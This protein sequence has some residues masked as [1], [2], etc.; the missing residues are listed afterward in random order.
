MER[1]GRSGNDG[2]SIR[3]PESCRDAASLCPVHLGWCLPRSPPFSSEDGGLPPPG[4]HLNGGQNTTFPSGPNVGGRISF[5]ENVSKDPDKYG[6]TINTSNASRYA[7]PQCVCRQLDFNL[8]FPHSVHV[9]ASHN[10]FVEPVQVKGSATAMQLELPIRNAAPYGPPKSKNNRRGAVSCSCDSHHEENR[11]GFSSVNSDDNFLSISKIS[12]KPNPNCATD[13]DSKPF[14]QKLR[15]GTSRKENVS[16]DTTKPIPVFEAKGTAGYNFGLPLSSPLVPKNKYVGGQRIRVCV[17]KRPLTRAECRRGQADV[18]TTTP[19]ED[20]VIVRESKEAV[21]LSEYI[22]QHKFYFDQVF[23]EGSS[24]EEVYQT[25]AFPLVQH[26]LNGGKATCFAYGQTGAGK[27]HTMLGSS[28]GEPGLYV[29]AVRDIFAH[30][31]TTHTHSSLLVYASFF[32]IYCGQLYD[33]LDSRKR[34][35]AREDGQKVVHISGLRNVRVDSVSSVLKVISQGTAERTQGVS[36]VNPLSS[37]SHAVLQIQLRGPNQQT[38][39]RMWFVDLAG[40]ERASDA[41][42][43]DRQTRMEGAEIN[44]SLLALKECIRS[45]DKDESHTPFRQSKLTQVLKDS[46]IGNS[47]T[48]MIASISPGHQA[49]EHTLNTLRY[50]DRVKELKGQAEVRGRRRCKTGPFSK[51][52][53]S[54]SNVGTP[55]KATK[56]SE[57]IEPNTPARFHTAG[58]FLRLTP[59]YS[60]CEEETQSKGRRQKILESEKPVRGWLA[61]GERESWTKE[62]DEEEGRRMTRGNSDSHHYVR[63]KSTRAAPALKPQTGQRKHKE[64]TCEDNLTFMVKECGFHRRKKDNSPPEWIEEERICEV[65]R[66]RERDLKKADTEKMRHL[67]QYHQHLQ[68]SVPSLSSSVHFVPSFRCPSSPS[69]TQDSLSSFLPSSRLSFVTH[70][71]HSLREILDEYAATGGADVDNDGPISLH[72]GETQVQPL[73]STNH[74]ENDA[75]AGSSNRLN[76]GWRLDES[77]SERKR[78]VEERARRGEKRL[79]VRKQAWRAQVEEAVAESANRTANGKSSN[80]NV[81]LSDCWGL[82]DQRGTSVVRPNA[83]DFS[84]KDMWRAAQTDSAHYD[85]VHQRAPAERPLSPSCNELLISDKLHESPFESANAKRDNILQNTPEAVSSNNHRERK[86]SFVAN[87]S[88]GQ[89]PYAQS[90]TSPVSSTRNGCI[91]PTDCAVYTHSCNHTAKISTFPQDETN[92]DSLSISLLHVDQQAAATSFLHST[93]LVDS[94]VKTGEELVEDEDASDVAKMNLLDASDNVTLTEQQKYTKIAVSGNDA[95]KSRISGFR[96]QKNQLFNNTATASPLQPPTCVSVL[97][98]LLHIG[99]NSSPAAH[100]PAECASKS[101][102]ITREKSSISAGHLNRAPS[103][104]SC[105]SNVLPKP[106]NAAKSTSNQ[107]IRP[108]MHLFTTDGSEYTKWCVV[109]AHLEQL[110]QM[111]AFCHKEGKLLWRQHKMAFGEYVQKLAEILEG[112]ARCLHSMR[113]QLQPFLTA[114]PSSKQGNTHF[115]TVM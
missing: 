6:A 50:A 10:R 79:A 98:P 52:N 97:T 22:L 15:E 85:L 76:D 16:P 33:L 44:Q 111:E 89:F 49:T 35:F 75:G 14:G 2:L 32:E 47:L 105:N 108:T 12:H 74:C 93:N 106:K 95:N 107:E 53:R 21:D 94:G 4:N 92:V 91:Q 55:K 88:E 61:N 81:Q 29:L 59:K 112:K 104:Y 46:F 69:S 70:M 5:G 41:K 27:T 82:K 66:Q 3:A 28:P 71:D 96:Q 65:E 67:K 25:T 78:L 40:S 86:N 68:Q 64:Q 87:A 115:H 90:A 17:R 51:H 24:N 30:L 8:E 83:S 54:S 23:G 60:R 36:G 18:V 11:R 102:S 113:A 103:H 63:E 56:L 58:V 1:K 62:A 34:L 77:E 72:R 84:D 43:P 100:N 99:N 26:M 80:V 45:L 57:T 39:G 73:T 110:K 13:T 19:G 7:G 38:G 42:E 20:C 114:S 101:S 31:S 37:R 109:E 48:C 9:S